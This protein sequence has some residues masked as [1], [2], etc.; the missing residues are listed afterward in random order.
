MESG[1]VRH[2]L[3]LGWRDVPLADL[4][5]KHV[6]ANLPIVIEN[7]ANAFA[8]AETH[9][10]TSQNSET[11]AF[12]V[13]ESGA[14]G[15]IVSGGRLFRGGGMAG[16]FGHLLMGGSG[17][18]SGRSRTGLL[19]NYIGKEAVLARY[20]MRGG[21]A[22]VSLRDFFTALEHGET[23]AV[24]TANDWARWLARGLLHI[25]NIINPELVIIGGSVGGIY[26]FIAPN[27][28]AILR[29]ELPNEFQ[30][31][32]IELSQFGAEGPALGTALL[33]HQRMFSVDER[34]FYPDG[35]ARGL[36]R[37]ASV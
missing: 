7:D 1:N 21:P 14:G 16:E 36:F 18:V 10:G 9:T 24:S 12:L 20:A 6:P 22:G 19:E 26:P 29:A 11:V 37:V 8:I 33:L 34:A 25:V 15:A 4:I 31:P 27:V 17:Y 3:L 23:A 35:G 30:M 13:V 28:D 32:K 5:K 2:G